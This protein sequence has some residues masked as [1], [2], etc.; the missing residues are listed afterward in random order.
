MR[1]ERGEGKKEK[2]K[3]VCTSMLVN[4]CTCSSYSN[5]QDK[6]YFHLTKAPAS[7]MVRQLEEP[8]WDEEV[9]GDQGG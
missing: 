6:L 3:N 2:R 7:D 1:E 5:G 4:A 9:V 8:S